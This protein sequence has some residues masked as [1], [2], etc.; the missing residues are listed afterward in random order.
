MNEIQK[1]VVGLSLANREEA[2]PPVTGVKENTGSGVSHAVI[3]NR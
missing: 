3:T 2:N 1:R